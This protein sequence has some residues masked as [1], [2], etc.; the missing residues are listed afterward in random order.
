MPAYATAGALV[1]VSILMLSGLERL[2]WSNTSELI[3][4]LIIVVMIPL[5]F[6][7]RWHCIRIYF[8]CCYQIGIGEFGKISSGAWFLTAVFLSKF[9]FL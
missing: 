8:I 9:I 2:N 7:S 5:S 3:P 1:Y 6:N 4:A